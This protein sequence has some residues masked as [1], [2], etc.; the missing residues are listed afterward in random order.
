MFYRR[1]NARLI[2]FLLHLMDQIK[3]LIFNNTSSHS[4]YLYPFKKP[5]PNVTNFRAGMIISEHGITFII[6][7]RPTKLAKTLLTLN[8]KI[9][10]NLAQ[11]QNL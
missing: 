4:M 9:K 7:L 6:G 11:N 1:G 2:K 3:G 5:N 10:L 8:H